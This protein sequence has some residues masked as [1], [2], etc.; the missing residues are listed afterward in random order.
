MIE[1]SL[2]YQTELPGLDCRSGGLSEGSAHGLKQVQVHAGV[3][4]QKCSLI[5]WRTLQQGSRLDFF[6]NVARAAGMLS[7]CSLVKVT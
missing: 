7:I 2:Q 5:C 4:I 6:R 3:M 1:P